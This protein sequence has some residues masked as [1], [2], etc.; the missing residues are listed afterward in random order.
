M[1]IF[2]KK[3][4]KSIIFFL[5]DKTFKN[6]FS[7]NIEFK[8]WKK[9]NE[10]RLLDENFIN[11]KNGKEQKIYYLVPGVSISGGIAVI[12]QHA[13]RLKD[14]GYDVKILSLSNDNDGSWFPNQKVEIFPYRKTKKVLQSGEVDILIATAYSTAFTVDMA[15]ARR[16]IYF[17]QSDESRFFPGNN[18]LCEIIKRTYALKMEY[19]TEA[20]WIQAWL[21]DEF[22]QDAHYV[23]NGIDLEVFKNT[24]PMVAKTKRPR[25]LIEG[26]I[27]VSYKGMDDAYDAAKDLDCELWIVSNNGKPKKDWRFDRFFENVPYGEMSKIY[28]S[29][30]V[31]LKMSRIEG[32][33]GPPMEAMACGCA[34]VVGK[35]TGFDEYIEDGENALVIEQEDIEGA[36]K[37]IQRLTEDIELRNKLINEGYATVKNWSWDRSSEALE[38]II[39]ETN[40]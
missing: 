8:R 16:K 38:R 29:C 28:S 1:K 21:K 25:V 12:F 10:E 17:V 39:N 14:D 32:F 31:F 22:G 33:F 36:K 34:V 20:K 13:N 6:F 40:Q 7:F 5:D 3:I 24:E 27:D 18:G 37:A 15:K 4:S 30:D 35:V 19:M 11:R 9:F 23:P 2:I 26:A